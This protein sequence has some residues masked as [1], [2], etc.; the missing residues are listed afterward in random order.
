M[1]LDPTRRML[2]ELGL[3][4]GGAAVISVFVNLALL[5]VPIYTLILYDR[6]LSSRNM[7]TLTALSIGC[8]GGM[9]LY[10]ILEFLRS[11]LFLVMGDRVARRLNLPTL[12]AA[13]ARTLDGQGSSAAQ[14]MRDLNELRGF[15]TGA[16]AAIP[17]DLLWSPVLVFVLFLLHPLYGWFGLGCAG[18]LFGISLAT[19]LVTREPLS[20]AA[21]AANSSVN[22]LAAVLRNGDLLDGMGMLPAV[23]RRWQSR[24][25]RTNATLDRASRHAR[26]FGA[27]AKTLRL[28][29]QGGIISLGVVLVI[30]NQATPGSLMAANLIVAKLLQPFEQLV[31]GWRQWMF[32]L[33]ALRRVRAVLS[34]RSTRLGALVADGSGSVVIDG[35]SFTP[36]G[37]DRPVLEDISLTIA[38]GEVLAIVGPSAAGKSTLARLIVGLFPPTHGA[39]RVDGLDS[40]AWDRAAFGRVVGYV[41]QSVAL[42]DG[43]IF[44]N[45]ARMDEADPARVVEAANLARVHEMIGRLPLGYATWVGGNGYS[46]SGGQRQR[47]A[48]ARAV[49]G[50][51]RLV[52]LDEPNA[53]LDQAGEE[54]LAQAILAIKSRGTGVVV[55][56]HRP[57]LLAVVDTLLVLKHGRI[58]HHGARADVLPRLT[59]ATPAPV[60]ALAAT[61]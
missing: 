16:A 43:T 29:M 50:G 21:T 34:H 38:P 45:I 18:L 39:V 20:A 46:L 10:G 59:D 5:I 7:D 9:I 22:D 13:I 15:V 60:P 31:G 6:I 24:L 25:N 23:A 37:R 8:I 32:A 40:T 35:V 55:V 52:V 12:Q 1:T 3:A 26:A 27:V 48:L 2:R 54:D 56:T 53:N 28:L 33:A 36:P 58:Q 42:L 44:D 47:V 49:F 11:S 57:A 19:D 17:L 4:Y 30:R 14:A 51:P 61:R 41:P